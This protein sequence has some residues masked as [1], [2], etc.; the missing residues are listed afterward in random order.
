MSKSLRITLNFQEIFDEVPNFK[1]LNFHGI[2]DGLLSW[3]DTNH[4]N[5]NRSQD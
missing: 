5:I 3:M 2:K 4:R 1:E